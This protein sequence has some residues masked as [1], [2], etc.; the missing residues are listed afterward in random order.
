MSL[1]AGHGPLSSQRAGWFAPEI[2]GDLVYVEPHPRR[3]W[4]LRG[5]RT[6]LD[7]ERVLLVHRRG[8]PLSY[9]FAC[10]AVGDLPSSEVP[11]APGF[12]QVPWDA[13][14]SWFEEGRR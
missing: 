7:T 2:I 11:E 8:H 6:V 9:A 5:D 1:V 13:V 4:A 10:D 3:V 14:D 12:V